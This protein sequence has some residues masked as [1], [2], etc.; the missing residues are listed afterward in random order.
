MHMH[1][2]MKSNIKTTHDVIKRTNYI[3]V[4]RMIQLQFL[5]KSIYHYETFTKPND[6]LKLEPYMYSVDYEFPIYKNDEYNKGSL[7]IEESVILDQRKFSTEIPSE[8]WNPDTNFVGN[9]VEFFNGMMERNE[10]TRVSTKNATENPNV[11]TKERKMQQRIPIPDKLIAPLRENRMKKHET[12]YVK[13]SRVIPNQP[14]TL[15]WCLYIGQY[16]LSKYTIMENSFGKEEIQEKQK[17]MEALK[18]PS[19]LHRWKQTNQKI[20]KVKIQQLCS[21]LMTNSTTEL[22]C[23]IAF[24]VYYQKNIYLVNHDNRTYYYF[25]CGVPDTENIY[26]AKDTP[27]TNKKSFSLYSWENANNEKEFHIM[28]T[29]QYQGLEN[30]EKSLKSISSYKMDELHEIANKMGFKVEDKMKKMEL[31]HGLLLYA[32]WK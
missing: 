24:S 26:I 2:H 4:Q 19:E 6:I 28:I 14:D 22:D 12:Y 21:D 7:V 17:I 25:S 30:T 27:R 1:M 29:T 18:S 10:A 13:D 8:G 11:I 31:Y 9:S 16:G 15:F 3:S 32:I 23:I 5:H 20:T